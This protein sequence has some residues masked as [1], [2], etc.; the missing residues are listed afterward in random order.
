MSYAVLS[1]CQALFQQPRY[2]K[3]NARRAVSRERGERRP[4]GARDEQKL[5]VCASD[6]DPAR[7]GMQLVQYPCG[8]CDFCI[9]ATG[10]QAGRHQSIAAT[11]DCP[12]LQR[13]LKAACKPE[14]RA[15]KRGL[16]S[17]HFLCNF[18]ALWTA[19]ES[20]SRPRR[21]KQE[22]QA[23][24]GPRL[25]DRL[26]TCMSERAPLCRVSIQTAR[27]SSPRELLT[28]GRAAACRRKGR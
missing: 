16:R 13:E 20:R 25:P 27:A 28:V 24:R 6:Q 4:L 1:C 18:V 2:S 10:V 12:V 23:S 14:T 15:S 3:V 5:E 11:A 8:R 26:L 7:D 19:Q 17:A 21:G 9:Q 22:L